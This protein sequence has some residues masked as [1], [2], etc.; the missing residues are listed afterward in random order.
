MI[1]FRQKEFV[2]PLAAI[3]SSLL[4]NGVV[5][6]GV[7]AAGQLGAAR[8]AAK[9]QEESDR[10]QERIAR[11]QNIQAA[12]DRQAQQKQ[13]QD[14][15]AFQ[16]QQLK[17]ANNQY[18]KQ[19]KLARKTGVS[20]TPN[21]T[22]TQPQQQQFS[23]ASEATGFVKNLGTLAKERGLHKALAGT[24]VAGAVAGGGA[25]LVDKAIQRDIKKSGKFEVAKP[26]KS[27]K[28]KKKRRRKLIAGAAGTAALLGGTIA[29]KKGAFGDKTKD[30]VSKVVSRDSA[31][32]VGKTF[33]DATKDYFTHT[34]ETGKRRVNKLNLALTGVSLASPAVMYRAKK[35]QYED[36]VK[37]SEGE[38]K[39]KTY[40]VKPGINL[41]KLGKAVKN[42]LKT[43]PK[44]YNGN[45]IDTT[46]RGRVWDSL[47]NKAKKTKFKASKAWKEFKKNPGESTLGAASSLLGG[48]GRNGVAKFG[49][50]LEALGEKTGNQ[51]S[52]KVGKAIRNNPKT[53]LAGSVVVGGL[54]L[55]K[56]R[57]KAWNATSR[58]LEKADPN[59][60]AYQKY[61]VQPIPE[62]DKEEKENE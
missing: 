26:E 50:D 14:Q 24:A 60:F 15:L 46:V 30:V 7:G 19:L 6:A 23:R 25:Y 42:N 31:G 54:V 35:K 2:L 13:A 36:Q 12:K 61:G 56:A 4:T 11:Q 21:I 41:G 39:E 62:K 37:Q 55:R 44:K 8:T 59:A 10:T 17:A 45:V 51:T 28:D 58:A 33:K 9:Q 1:K 49:D 5:S 52:Q 3:G 48:G 22:V 20:V 18:N 57:N 32:K 47:L 29:A 53:A 34:D 16:K 27:E 43:K 40:A 38:E